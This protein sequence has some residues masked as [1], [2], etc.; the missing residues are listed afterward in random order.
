MRNTTASL[1]VRLKALGMDN[2][3]S[4][5]LAHL[6]ELFTTLPVPPDSFGLYPNY[7][8]LK[9]E[10]VKAIQ[11]D[12]DPFLLEEKFLDLYCHVHCNEAPYSPSERA[13]VND[14]GGYWCHAG[15]LSPILKAGPF[16]HKDSVSIDLGA[17]NGLQGLLLQTLY[18]HK[19]TIQVEISRKLVLAGRD[20]QEWLGIP[21]D[22]VDW[23]VKDLF[24]FSLPEVDFIYLYRPLKPR[25]KGMDYYK[26]LARTIKC[27]GRDV[28]IFSIA[29]C[30]YDFLDFPCQVLYDDGHLKCYRKK[31]TP[32]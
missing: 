31:S 3:E 29:D 2:S 16:L 23:Q 15:G 20:L 12:D 28:T 1:A 11:Q 4:S 21:D 14:T 9:N 13:V 17:G 19:L 24:E 7:T 22:R 8:V 27:A 30:L 32:G 25:D 18:P 6:M 26:R 10:L 5:G